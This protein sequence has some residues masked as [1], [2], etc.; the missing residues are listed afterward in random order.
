M[1]TSLPLIQPR[2]A[3]TL[4]YSSPTSNAAPPHQPASANDPFTAPHARTHPSSSSATLN[5]MNPL[6]ALRAQ[7]NFIASRKANIARFGAHWIRPAGVGKTYQAA[8][9]E[10]IEREEAARLAERE[11]AMQ[12]LDGAWGEE[13]EEEEAVEGEEGVE[14]DA[15]EDEEEE[16]DLDEEVPE[17]GS[18]QHTDTSAS[19][20]SDADAEVDL[21]GE[22]PEASQQHTDTDSSGHGDEDGLPTA[23]PVQSRAQT[24]ALRSA[25]NALGSAPAA[26]RGQGQGQG[27]GGR[28]RR[29]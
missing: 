19:D 13:E 8:M 3:H 6:A 12:E 18:Y 22:I 21:D 27:Q 9:D 11:A 4:W 15:V 28:R 26:G 16:V 25:S 7:E 2:D 20:A 1:F 14:E 23:A 10:A 5:T 24:G 17:A 29:P